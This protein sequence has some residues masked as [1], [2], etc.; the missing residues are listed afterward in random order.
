MDFLSPLQPEP[1]E[2]ITKVIRRIIHL[3]FE[4]I[5]IHQQMDDEHNQRCRQKEKGKPINFSQ[6]DGQ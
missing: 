6:I 3:L 4:A 2:I 1:K 5:L